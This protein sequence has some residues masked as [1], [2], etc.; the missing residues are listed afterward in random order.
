MA[1]A[2][3]QACENNIPQN[4]LK[5]CGTRRIIDMA[6]DMMDYT[7]TV[8]YGKGEKI[9]IKIGIHTGKVIAGVI[10]NFNKNFY[11]IFINI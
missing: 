9:C 4:L 11:Y 5:N 2:G 8:G 10:G 3:I 1:A 7:S 6:F